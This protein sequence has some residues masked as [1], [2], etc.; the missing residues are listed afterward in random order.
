MGRQGQFFLLEEFHLINVEGMRETGS[1]HENIAVLMAEEEI[2]SWMLKLVGECF[3]SNMACIVVKYV[4]PRY[5]L[6]TEEKNNNFTMGQ[7]W[8][9]PP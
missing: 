9:T 2:H 4:P 8:Q 3:R 7:T 5:L 1:H 6:I